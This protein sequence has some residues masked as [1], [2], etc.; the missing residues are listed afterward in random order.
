V[1]D[2]SMDALRYLLATM[3]GIKA[4]ADLE[5]I[6]IPADF[7][8]ASTEMTG[9]W[10]LIYVDNSNANVVACECGA[11]HVHWAPDEHSDWCPA[12]IFGLKKESKW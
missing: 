10:D 9:V 7:K 6:K 8:L 3:S 2:D 11:K 12:A 4:Y 1:R 5:A